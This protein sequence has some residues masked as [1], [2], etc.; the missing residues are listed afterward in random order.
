MPIKRIMCA[1]DFSR[2]AQAA[3]KYA[4]ELSA[5]LQVP[6]L[7]ANSYAVPLAVVPAF[8]GGVIPTSTAVA[9]DLAERSRKL[10]EACRAATELGA[11]GVEAVALEGEP[12]SALITAA[13][14]R[15]VD[16]LAMGTHGRSGLARALIGS[17]TD[18]VVRTAPCPVFVVHPTEGS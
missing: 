8:E 6:L 3:L 9:E 7:I 11:I 1:T 4:A 12:A 10:D 5:Q 17:V 14:E 15:G 2:P 16:M 13:H 18:K